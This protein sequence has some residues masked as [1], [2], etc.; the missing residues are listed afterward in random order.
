MAGM[1]YH[2]E[3]GPMFAAFE[4]LYNDPNRLPT[5][6]RDLR[7]GGAPSLGSHGVLSSPLADD[8]TGTGAN[9]T[10]P[11]RLTSMRQYW[12]GEDATTPGP[13]PPFNIDP[14]QGPINLTTGY[15]ALYYGDVRTIVAETLMRAAEVALGVERPNPVSSAVPAASRNWKV[16]FFWKCGQPRFEGWVTWRDHKDGA[17]GG[18]VTVVFATPA[19]PDQVLRAPGGGADE[20]TTGPSP[21]PWQGMWLCTHENHKQYVLIGSLPTPVRA[22]FVPTSA[23]MFTRGVD[24]VKTWAPR[25]GQ[26]GAA[27]T[28]AAFVSGPEA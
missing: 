17:N 27:P 25:F 14:A 8:P 5:F 15:W 10:A 22:W 28:A 2:L 19:T 20:V 1:P 26:G 6:L 12:F 9:A 7:M 3:K 18:Q 4:A 21:W 16:E 13:Q 24:S 11:Q 23:V